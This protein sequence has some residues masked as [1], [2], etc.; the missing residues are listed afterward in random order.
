MSEERVRVVA[1]DDVDESSGGSPPPI[2]VVVVVALAVVGA[3]W[4]LTLPPEV[5]ESELAV[6]TSVAF[7]ETRLRDPSPSSLVPIQM[8]GFGPGDL[9]GDVA[10]TSPLPFSVPAS[11][12]VLRPSGAIV[13]LPDVL[14]RGGPGKYPLLMTSERI[15][16]ANFSRGYLLD[17]D[18]AVPAEPLASATFVV[19]GAKEGLVW[20]VRSRSLVGDVNWVAPVDVDAQTVGQQFNVADLFSGVVAGVGDGLIVNPVDQETYGRYAY[21]S[22]SAGLAPLD[23][24]VPDREIVVSASGDLAVVSLGNRVSVFDT[25]DGEYVMWFSRDLGGAVT[26]ACLSRDNEHLVVV[27]SNG[28]AFVGNVLTG[29]LFPLDGHVQESH[30]VGWTSNDQLAYLVVSDNGRTV[31]VRNSDGSGGEIAVLEGAGYWLL[32]ASGSMC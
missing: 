10:L 3:G 8:S 30:G 28:A 13:R 32:T 20:F 31:G 23:L 7:P 24:A 18:A 15:A 29:E 6:S 1:I 14:I 4:L 17:A 22:P 16:F 27:G 26:S 25:R 5:A 9:A 2:W 11:L 19:P 21:W 12:W